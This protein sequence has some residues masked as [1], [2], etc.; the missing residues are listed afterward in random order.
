MAWCVNINSTVDPKA[1]AYVFFNKTSA[2]FPNL[3][4]CYEACRSE[5]V[6]YGK[7]H[8]K[9][10]NACYCG[11]RFGLSLSKDSTKKSCK[12]KVY[13][14]PGEKSHPEYDHRVRRGEFNLVH[15]FAFKCRSTTVADLHTGT[16]FQPSTPLLLANRATSG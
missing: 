3:D 7:Q 2:T 4:A 13:G 11:T 14:A 9:D 1:H 6:A 8:T 12:G 15:R 10:E 5:F 16:P